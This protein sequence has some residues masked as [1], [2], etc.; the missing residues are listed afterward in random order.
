MYN[1]LKQFRNLVY[2]YRLSDL[3]KSISDPHKSISHA[4]KSIK[5]ISK[6][7]R[8]KTWKESTAFTTH[9]LTAVLV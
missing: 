2:R 3:H 5:T 9:T 8:K 6:R 7:E 4:H 1:K